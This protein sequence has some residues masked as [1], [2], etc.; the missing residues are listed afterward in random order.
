MKLGKRHGRP[1]RGGPHRI[2]QGS[3]GRGIACHRHAGAWRSSNPRS[4]TSGSHSAWRPP[5]PS[6]PSAPW[7]T[8]LSSPPSSGSCGRWSIGPTSMRCPVAVSPPSRPSSRSSASCAAS[9][10]GWAVDPLHCQFTDNQFGA[11]GE[12]KHVP[13]GEGTLRVG[14][15]I[16]AAVRTGLRMTLISE[17]HDA[18]S[19]ERIQAEVEATLAAA[20]ARPAR[21]GHPAARLRGGSPFPAPVRMAADGDGWAPVGTHHARC[22]SRTRTRSSSRPMDTPREIC[23]STTHRSPRCCCRI[24]QGRAIVMSRYPDGADGPV[25]LREA[26]TVAS[27]RLASAGPAVVAA[28]RRADRVRHGSRC[29]VAAVDRQ[30]GRHRDPPVAEQGR[31]TR[32]SDPGHLRSRPGRRRRLGAGGRRG[33]IGSADRC[34][35]S[36]WRGIPRPVAPPDCTSTCRWPRSTTTPGC[37]ASS[38]RSEG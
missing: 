6:E 4:A 16:E 30:P 38:K 1:G 17:A 14:P 3:L 22:A 15:L 7:A 18:G 28:P 31:D 20:Q 25:L 23:C 29:R 33:R 26:G 10:P 19:H 36:A 9:S 13:Y 27:A 34:S 35:A 37:G 12:I 21:G 8:S 32:P 11:K 2:H 5:A 24:W